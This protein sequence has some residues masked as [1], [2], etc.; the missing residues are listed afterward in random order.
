MKRIE[1]PADIVLR[2]P[3][4]KK[5]IEDV[6]LD[7]S[8]GKPLLD[9]DQRTVYKPVTKSFRDYAGEAWLN[10]QRIAQTRAQLRRRPVI[11]AAFDEAKGGGVI[12][13]EDAD[14]AH[15]KPIVEERPLVFSPGI[16]Q[17]LLAFDDAFLAAK[18]VK[19]KDAAE[20]DKQTEATN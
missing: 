16:E 7:P 13:L 10:D 5:I 11:E 14:Y 8:T 2:N 12:Y 9:A 4:T 6:V 18:D 15:V 19:T 17:Q 1:V 3:V 20:P